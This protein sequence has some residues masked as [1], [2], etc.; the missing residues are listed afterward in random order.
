MTNRFRPINYID[1]LA[2]VNSRKDLDKEHITDK[3]P[4]PCTVL[5]AIE[6]N[7]SVRYFIFTVDK[8]YEL[9][10]DT[11]TGYTMEKDEQGIYKPGDYIDEEWDLIIITKT[12]EVIHDSY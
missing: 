5:N 4:D 2:E 7:R 1:I 9:Y 6:D 11:I 3:L 8:I 12:G 10:I